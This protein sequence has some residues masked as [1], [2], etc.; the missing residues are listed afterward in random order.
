MWEA[1]HSFERLIR[2]IEGTRI[3]YRDYDDDTYG[4]SEH[5]YIGTCR[6]SGIEEGTILR[7]VNEEKKHC[8]SISSALFKK[9]K[10]VEYF[11]GKAIVD[12]R[13]EFEITIADS[14]LG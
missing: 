11:N 4:Y 14:I 10:V 12:N 3:R 1:I 6:N 13:S 7:V 2:L 5:R 9:Y 8:R